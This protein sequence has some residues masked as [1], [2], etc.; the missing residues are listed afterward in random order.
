MA[1]IGA[2]RAEMRARA[3]LM[4]LRDNTGATVSMGVLDETWV[5]YILRFFGHRAGQYEAD[6]GLGVGARV[7]LHCTAIG[8]ALLASLGES[9]QAEILRRLKLA[10]CGPKTVTDPQGLAVELARVRFE[11][12]AVC[13]EEQAAGARS[14]ARA[15]VRPGGARPVAISM[16][17]PARGYTARRVRDDFA[18]HLEA[19]VRLMD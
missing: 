10:R 5:I 8:K 3:I 19:A 18:V 7:P 4:D 2:L 17:A 11:G 6:L 13:D 1:A 9:E 16:T 14:I 15:V 12:F